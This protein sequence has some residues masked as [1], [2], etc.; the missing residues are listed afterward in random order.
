MEYNI[1]AKET[2]YNGR[3]FK[4]RLEARWA[5][6]FDRVGWTWDYEPFEI[7]GI[8]PDF[9]IRCSSSAYPCSG[10]I[11]EVKPSIF[12]SKDYMSKRLGIY[13]NFKCHVLFLTENPFYK[14]EYENVCIGMGIQYFGEEKDREGS[15]ELLQLEMKCLNDFGSEYMIFDGMIEGKI[16]RKWFIKMDDREAALLKT[17][18]NEAGNEFTFTYNKKFS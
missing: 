2:T 6:F 8:Y 3:T 11:I 18:W 1:K 9:C 12:M 7:G 17:M 4:S 16:E 15:S 10:I 5:C 13:R 14:S